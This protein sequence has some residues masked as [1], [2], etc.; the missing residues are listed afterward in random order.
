MF[1]MVV[2]VQPVSLANRKPG[3]LKVF[4]IPFTKYGAFLPA[5]IK[6]YKM[7]SVTILTCIGSYLFCIGYIGYSKE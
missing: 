7:S 6:E 3:S 4:N 2:T 5:Y 1:L